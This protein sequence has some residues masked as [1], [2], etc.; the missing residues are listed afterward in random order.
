MFMTINFFSDAN[1]NMGVE[2]VINNMKAA[3]IKE[4]VELKHKE[5]NSL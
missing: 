4:F 5:F 1:N 3:I 2:V